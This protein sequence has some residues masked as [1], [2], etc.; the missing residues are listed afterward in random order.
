MPNAHNGHTTLIGTIVSS[1]CTIALEDAWQAVDMG[2]IPI[3]DFSSHGHGL[4]RQIRIH[5][6][7]CSIGQQ[8]Q[9][10]Y[11]PAVHVSF[12]GATGSEPG[13]FSV[14]GTAKGVGL[15]IK[16]INGRVIRPKESQPALPVYGSE[17]VMNYTLQII[18]DGSSLSAGDYSAA[19]KFSMNY[20]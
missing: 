12:H 20:E 4:A 18:R 8:E 10:S 19:I 2:I 9:G 14:N 11:Q 6:R 1:A 7:N 17:Q 15:L 5:L 16:D 13:L 3:R